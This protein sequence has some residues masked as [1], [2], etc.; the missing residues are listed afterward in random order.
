MNASKLGLYVPPILATFL[1]ADLSKKV[2]LCVTLATEVN[3]DSVSSSPP[4]VIPV[5]TLFSSKIANR[6]VRMSPF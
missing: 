2:S 5:T 6:F 3:A 4:V 1:R